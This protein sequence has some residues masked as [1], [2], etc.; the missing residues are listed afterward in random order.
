MTPNRKGTK[1]VRRTF[2]PALVFAIVAIAPV[3]AGANPLWAWW[4]QDGPPT[5][6]WGTSTPYWEWALSSET[7]TAEASQDLDP[8]HP[9]YACTEITTGDYSSWALHIQVGLANNYG[10]RNRVVVELRK[11]SWGSEG[12]LMAEDTV[13]VTARMP[14]AYPYVSNFRPIPGLVL[15]NESLIVKIIYL[16]PAGDTRI[17]WGYGDSSLYGGWVS[18]VQNSTWGRIKALYGR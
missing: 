5:G 7:G 15:D 8:D 18:A 13:T 3:A 2:L 1:A 14:E 10:S 16:G 4:F 9:F 11:G 12:T 17:F 6:V